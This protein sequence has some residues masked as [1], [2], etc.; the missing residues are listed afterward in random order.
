MIWNDHSKLEGQH[1]FLSP[2]KAS[3][4]NW[5]E[6]TLEQ[7]YYSQ[8]S[9]AIGT[10]VHALAKDLITSRRKLHKYDHL[11]VEHEL[12]KNFIPRYAYDVDLILPNLIPFVNDGI[13]FDMSAEVILY[14]NSY[15]FGTADAIAYDTNKN[16]LRIH[17]LKSG[18]TPAKMEQLLLYAALFVL[19]Y[20]P[21]PKKFSTLQTELRIYQ[22]VQD[23]SGYSP[24]IMVCNPTPD[25]IATFANYIRSESQF[26]QHLKER[27]L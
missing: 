15:C 27:E 7:R 23:D 6:E 22:N 4:I 20:L 3:W 25:E 24:N 8:Y 1:A 2:S 17:D 21:N 18:L 10:V 13:G 11:I 19:E 14:Y 26:L 16:F 9:Q 5:D 12:D